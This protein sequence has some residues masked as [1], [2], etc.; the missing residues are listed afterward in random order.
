[1]NKTFFKS[2]YKLIYKNQGNIY[3]TK[4]ET[5]L[6]NNPKKNFINFCKHVLDHNKIISSDFKEKLFKI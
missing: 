4:D 1:M 3:V 2:L 5:F 6:H